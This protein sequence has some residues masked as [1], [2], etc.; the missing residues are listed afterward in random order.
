MSP[1]LPSL[2]FFP[3]ESSRSIVSARSENL[4]P[5]GDVNINLFL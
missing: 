5:N 2:N 4:F 3:R 1:P